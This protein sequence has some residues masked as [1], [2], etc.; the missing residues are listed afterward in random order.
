MK[1]NVKLIPVKKV[2]CVEIFGDVM[3]DEKKHP[4]SRIYGMRANP[5][6][7]TPVTKLYRP[8][9]PGDAMLTLTIKEARSFARRVLALTRA[10]GDTE[11]E[12]EAENR[13]L[14]LR[15]QELEQSNKALMVDV[16]DGEGDDES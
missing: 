6:T 15:V 12:I 3:P 10:E 14:R 13:E 8:D 16:V 7:F 11:S 4:D 2:D 9:G 1:M 5:V